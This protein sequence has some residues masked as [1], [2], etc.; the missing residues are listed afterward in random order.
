MEWKRR[1]RDH[2]SAVSCMSLL[3]LPID[4]RSAAR[5]HFEIVGAISLKYYY[6]HVLFA[7][8]KAKVWDVNGVGSGACGRSTISLNWGISFVLNSLTASLSLRQ[9]DFTQN[10]NQ[11]IR[12]KWKKTP[13]RKP[14]ERLLHA[15]LK[16]CWQKL[17]L[18]MLAAAQLLFK[19][20]IAPLTGGN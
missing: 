12:P 9:T 15:P 1:A 20:Q 16:S 3:R 11:N 13:I 17:S 2:N 19:N 6:R 14:E 7:R 5:Q 18:M 4:V 8:S 10:R